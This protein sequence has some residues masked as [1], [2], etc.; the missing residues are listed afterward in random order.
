[1]SL[2]KRG[3]ALYEYCQKHYPQYQIQASIAWIEAGMSLKKKPAERAKTKHQTP[4]DAWE[5][6]EGTYKEELRLCFLPIDA[7]GT[8]GYWFGF[9]AESQ[10]TTPVFKAKTSPNHD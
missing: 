6:L 3:L 8:Y 2:E 4:P 5:I 10:R 7:E 1:M 9:E